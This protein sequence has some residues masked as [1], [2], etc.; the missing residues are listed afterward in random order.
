MSN[1]QSKGYISREFT[2][3]C[4]GCIEWR[5]EGA[6]RQALAAKAF[7]KSGWKLTEQKGWLCPICVENG[8]RNEREAQA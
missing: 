1:E 5:Q 6:A 3:W 8:P 4:G 2:V 7:R